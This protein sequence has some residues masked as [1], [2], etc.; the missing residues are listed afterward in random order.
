MSKTIDDK[1]SISDADKAAG[2]KALSLVGEDLIRNYAKSLNDIR[3]KTLYLVINLEDFNKE[4]AIEEL[5]KYKSRLLTFESGICRQDSKALPGAI[6][7]A[8]HLLVALY[9]EFKGKDDIMG[10][11][12]K[13][14]YKLFPVREGKSNNLIYIT[15]EEPLMEKDVREKI[16]FSNVENLLE[17]SKGD[18]D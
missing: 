18:Y 13:I 8:Q 4:S 14:Y 7:Y 17:Y 5:Q 15:N 9:D 12:A 6:N 3:K 16:L 1:V 2:E 11:I 10:E